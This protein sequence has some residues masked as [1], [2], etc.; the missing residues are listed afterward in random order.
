MTCPLI[1]STEASIINGEK[2]N[3]LG[4]SVHPLVRQDVPAA[5]TL[6]VREEEEA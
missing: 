3:N 1:Q 6:P 2:P 4:P 5:K